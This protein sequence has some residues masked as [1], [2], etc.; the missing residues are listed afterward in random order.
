MDSVPPC[1][2]HIEGNTT[3]L[4]QLKERIAKEQNADRKKELTKRFIQFSEMTR[5]N[6]NAN[7]KIFYFTNFLVSCAFTPTLTSYSYSELSS[8][9]ANI[10]A[11][12]DV[13]IEEFDPGLDGDSDTWKAKGI[14]P[15]L[16]RTESRRFAY[17]LKE[18]FEKK[19]LLRMLHNT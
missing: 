4:K 5:R 11:S 15:E 6:Y 9:G 7:F 2:R 13:N 18:A 12:L 1:I 3:I 14:W 17:K 19:N 16:R 10:S 8:L